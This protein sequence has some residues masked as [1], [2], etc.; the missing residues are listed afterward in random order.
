MVQATENA[1][2]QLK[3]WEVSA[4]ESSRINGQINAFVDSVSPSVEIMEAINGTYLHLKEIIEGSE[5]IRRNL[6][7]HVSLHIYGSVVNG[8]FDV[9]RESG[10]GGMQSDLDLTLIVDEPAHTRV[11]TELEIL[12]MIKNKLKTAIR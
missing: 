5:T 9:Q 12:E 10:N 3:N 6:K 2:H 4:E 11:W 1:E 8:L 7:G